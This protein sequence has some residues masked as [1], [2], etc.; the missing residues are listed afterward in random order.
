MSEISIRLATEADAALIAGQRRAMFADAVLPVPATLQAM[1]ACF[2]PWVRERLATGLYRGWIAESAGLPV[3]G[4]GLWIAEFPPHFLDIA[5]ARGY[6]LNFYVLPEYRGA[7]LARR[8]LAVAV[9]EGR[10]LRLRVITLHASKFG[11]K[12]YEQNGF[13]SNNE[14][15]LL[16]DGSTEPTS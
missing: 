1:E 12:L 14:M 3:G 15:I 5:A 6:L 7:G 11:R 4:A 16:S 9:E 10:R 13:R 2:K 8:L